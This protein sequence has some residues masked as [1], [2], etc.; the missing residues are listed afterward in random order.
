MTDTS[1]AGRPR[2]RFLPHDGEELPG[3]P[4]PD[5]DHPEIA[6][7]LVHQLVTE[8][9]REISIS[10][11]PEL[12]PA[13]TGGTRS[14]VTEAGEPGDEDIA[15]A[16]WRDETP[17]DE[18][19]EQLVREMVLEP[20]D[21]QTGADRRKS[22]F[23][24]V[25][26]PRLRLPKPGI[27]RRLARGT[28]GARPATGLGLKKLP[29]PAAVRGYRP[30]RK[31]VLLAAFALL[32]LLRPV[33]VGLVVLILFWVVLIAYLTIGPDRWGEILAGVWMRLAEKRPEMA[34][35]VRQRA[36]AFAIRFDRCLDWLP[37]SWADR[38]ALPDFS[39]LPVQGQEDDRPDPFDRLA[40]E[41][42]QG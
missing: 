33:M 37:E 34:E 1:F 39:Q 11:L 7:T 25:R 26:M 42:R 21:I 30:T 13:S 40:A 19:P 9:K 35:R 36:D 8:Q 14:R 22:V 23:A 41:A 32:V 12:A 31:H 10:V 27:A 15:P 16:E 6:E 18:I 24:R 17:A 38:L 5:A 2:R 29:I 20:D 28:D 3:A 4:A